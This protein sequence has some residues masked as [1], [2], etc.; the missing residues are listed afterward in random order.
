MVVLGGAIWWL[1]PQ[2]RERK[3]VEY[4]RRARGL[5][6]DE[7][8][9]RFDWDMRDRQEQ[10]AEA[11]ECRE[12]KERGER[13]GPM[14]LEACREHGISFDGTAGLGGPWQGTDHLERRA[15]TIK[16]RLSYIIT[17]GP[18]A[19][20]GRYIDEAKA[21]IRDLE[22]QSA[23]RGR[24]QRWKNS[25][26]ATLRTAIRKAERAAGRRGLSAARFGRDLALAC[27]PDGC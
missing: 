15:T 20:S 4:M 9:W 17:D 13:P 5:G 11:R 25:H 16:N 2:E 6:N 24:A 19:K 18:N 22:E 8:A 3:S 21:F 23:P 1:M 12:M 10:A 14:M 27:G 7:R 26:L